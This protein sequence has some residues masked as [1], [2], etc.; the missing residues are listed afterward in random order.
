MRLHADVHE[1]QGYGNCVAVDPKHFD[2][3]DDGIVVILKDTVAEEDRAV[4]AD[5]VRSCPA[6][7]LR[8]TEDG[9]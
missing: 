5:A 8:M 3:D 7:A 9:E 2:L 1:C 4:A 6:D